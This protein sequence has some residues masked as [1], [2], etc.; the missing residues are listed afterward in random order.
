MTE[1]AADPKQDGAPVDA[2]TW[3]CAARVLWFRVAA[4]RRRDTHQGTQKPG[5][6]LVG[7]ALTRRVDEKR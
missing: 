5:V 7:D 4:Q 2:G 6:G 1:N 3:L